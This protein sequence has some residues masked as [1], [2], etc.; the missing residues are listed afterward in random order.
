MDKLDSDR[1]SSE[2]GEMAATEL[3]EYLQKTPVGSEFKLE[4]SADLCFI[5]ERY[6]P[7]LLSQRYPEWAWES[8]DGIFAAHSQRTDSNTAEIAGMCLLISDQTMTPF[9]IRLTLSPS[10]D[11][12]ASCHLL[13]GEP[14]GG[15]LG[16]SGPPCHS[17]K[18]QGLLETVKARLQGIRWSY[19][20]TSE[21]KTKD[22][23]G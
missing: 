6:I 20:L 15:A 23:V 10:H 8:L 22:D 7:Q 14:G 12:V 9:F 13:L 11:A 2:I 1:G 17:F 19:T 18:A 21:A 16:I 5:L 4:P 3:S